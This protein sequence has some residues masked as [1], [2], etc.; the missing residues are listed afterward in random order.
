M[1]VSPWLLAASIGL[2]TLI[3]VVF[4][5]NNMR[6]EVKLINDG[7]Y[8][9]G[10][11]L[12]RF[13]GAGTRASMLQGMG[14]AAHTQRLIEQAS[15]EQDILYI[16]VIDD[17]GKI[18][19]HSEPGKV[20][21]M[22][23]REINKPQNPGKG[24]WHIVTQQDNGVNIF[25]V[26]SEF[27]PFRHGIYRKGRKRDELRKSRR[28]LR[29]FNAKNEL[30]DSND[31]N[32]WCRLMVNQAEDASWQGKIYTILV[33]LDM[34]EQDQI[35]RQAKLH[36]VLLSLI[37]LFVGLGGWLTML[38]SQSYKASQ[39]T[40]KHIQ[41]FTN[42]LIMKL[43]VGIIAT[44]H[45]GIIKTYNRAMADMI[46]IF[47]DQAI[48]QLPVNVLPCQLAEFFDTL[49]PGEEIFEKEITLPSSHGNLVAHVSSVPVLD[50]DNIPAGRVLLVHDLTKLK[51]LEKEVMQHDRLVALGK[52]AAGVAHEVRNPLSSIKGFATLL[53]AKHTKGSEEYKASKLLVNEVD[54]LNRSITELLNYSRPLPLNLKDTV[55]GNLLEESILLMQSD[56]SELGVSLIAS[57]DN[58]LPPVS[59]DQDRIKQVMLNLLL[60]AFQ[61]ID[62]KGEVIVAARVVTEKNTI[63]ITVHDT[64]CGISAEYIER[65]TDPYYTTK[66]QGTG[67]GLAL[68]YKI[69]DEHNGMLNFESQ[70]GQGTKVTI[71]LPISGLPPP[72]SDSI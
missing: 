48:N 45:D 37:V 44:E 30:S 40:L 39:D 20:G 59:V 14:G 49:K 21:E 52:M 42:L 34:T 38:I 6:R 17:S 63:E 8:L 24:N 15:E 65:V 35:T 19:A 10:Q 3:V 23:G 26:I 28:Q 27:S 55:L 58:D 62:G 5:A 22:L 72:Q 66:A 7:L 29:D 69:I 53:G 32:D 31:S 47:P 68:V 54:R 36:I 9:R 41:A 33:G 57:I 12:A 51:E 70:A 46:G 13:V 64:G 18:M 25:E 60:N 2:M 71:T 43:P 1:F 67:L 56:A 16:A 50:D 11:S 4:A 61:A